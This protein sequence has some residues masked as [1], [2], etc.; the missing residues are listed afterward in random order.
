MYLGAVGRSGTTLLERSAATAPS[1]VSLGELVH[2][3]ERGARLDQPCGCGEPFSGCPFW[4]AVG[5]RAFGGWEQLD[6]DQVLGWQRDADRNR[7]VP[8]LLVPRLGSRRFRAA[9]ASF[10]SVLERLYGAIDDEVAERTGARRVLV[11]ASKHPSYLFVLRRL[12]GH[13]VRLLHVVRD[14]RGVAHSWAKVVERPEAAGED[15][16]RLDTAHAIARWT[17]HNLLF[18]LAAA[19]GVRRRRL[20]YEAFATD[21]DELGRRLA[22]LT[23]DLRV[24]VPR[25][26]DHTAHLGTDHTVSGNP[27]RFRTGAVVIRPDD[28]WRREMPART[29]RIVTVLTAPLRLAY[30]T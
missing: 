4:T 2:L 18:Q 17:S 15:M 29:R 10:T 7:F 16:E 8:L 23:E 12:R 20:R 14:P 24:E 3:W 27:M 25:F 26:A 19:T 13:R 22:A 30:R 6:I 1:F 9:L 5:E 21:P 28:A 11:D